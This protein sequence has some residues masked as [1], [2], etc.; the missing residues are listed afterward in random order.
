[1]LDY[2]PNFARLCGMQ[3]KK[4][5]EIEV[6]IDSLVY[7]GR[8]I[9]E[10]E[11]KKVFVDGVAPGDKV[12]VSLT[13]I[14][15]RF[16]EA[17][18]RE[19]LEEGAVRIEPR[20][21]HFDVCGGC[22]WQFLPYEEQLR[23][24]EQQVRD[25]VE[26]I[27]GFSGD[28][29]GEILGCEEPWF[30]RN[31]MELSFGPKGMLGFYPPGYHYEVFD[32]EEC[33]LQSTQVA[34]IAAKVREFA[35]VNGLEVFDKKSHEG[36]LRNL[37][38]REGKNTGE[39]MVNLVTAPGEFSQKEEFVRLM[40]GVDSVWWTK[41]FQ[42]EG[43]RTR[44]EEELLAGKESLVEK[45]GD[46]KFDILPQAFFQTNTKQAEMLY[47][48]VVEAACLKGDEVVL[49]L[50]CGTGTIGLFCAR[51]ARKVVGVEVNAAAVESAKMNA[52]RNGIENAEFYLGSVDSV[53]GELPKADVVIVD[54]P[55]SGL[56][57]K[58]VDGVCE[59]GAARIVYVSCN[60]ATLARDAA[61]LRERGYSLEGVKPVDMFPQTSHVESVA[62]LSR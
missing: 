17:N 54:P 3:I 13:R 4:G 61:W 21:K 22:K 26:R 41:V 6:R 32:L 2:W 8:G 44:L 36:F 9:G 33:F 29:V 7:G 58:V 50:Y 5:T 25:S 57:E 45:L 47:S 27:G 56:G 37:V 40:E 31:K 49:D 12:R 10:Y 19:V 59:F 52:K 24:K 34:E 28:L 1:M 55:R 46:L 51:Q 60:P 42:E 38:I 62:V 11:G 16:M 23:V 43:R 14:K 48:L 18:L 30:Y 20:C 39:I 15:P 53:L 35:R